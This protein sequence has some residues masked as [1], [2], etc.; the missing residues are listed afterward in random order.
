MM[1]T[2][3]S[4]WW[5]LD[6]LEYMA[7]AN[8]DVDAQKRIAEHLLKI[9]DGFARKAMADMGVKPGKHLLEVEDI[10]QEVFLR[11]WEKMP[12][13]ECKGFPAYCGVTMRRII[14]RRLQK[15]K[16]EASL[17]EQGD[18]ENPGFYLDLV[19]F[20]ETDVPKHMDYKECLDVINQMID[21][22]PD[23]QPTAIRSWMAGNSYKEICEQTGYSIG[24]LSKIIFTI[25]EKLC[26]A[27]ENLYPEN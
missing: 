14:L 5:H 4:K 25:R 7:A 12:E 6:S 27:I 9:L 24:G 16:R 10:V 22:L 15:G 26:K 2:S 18:P 11:C 21:E 3:Q 17:D 23:P 8:G 13:V 20:S 19:Q 1:T